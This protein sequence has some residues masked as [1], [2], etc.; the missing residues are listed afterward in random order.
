[1]WFCLLHSRARHVIIKKKKVRH[2]GFGFFREPGSGGRRMKK[3]EKILGNLSC[4]SD[5]RCFVEYDME[6]FRDLIADF[7]VNWVENLAQGAGDDE[8]GCTT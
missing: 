8:P 1:M 5:L 4:T 3:E 6:A 2:T 7:A